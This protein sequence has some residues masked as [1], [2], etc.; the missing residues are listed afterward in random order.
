MT[1]E[2][3]TYDYVDVPQNCKMFTPEQIRV[4]EVGIAES[5]ADIAAGR[6][7]SLYKV[8]QEIRSAMKN[9]TLGDLIAKCKAERMK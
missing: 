7:H 2:M 8:E 5:D 3:Q 1:A 4:I 6:V 9:G